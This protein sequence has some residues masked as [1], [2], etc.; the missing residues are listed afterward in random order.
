MCKA[1]DGYLV[2]TQNQHKTSALAMCVRCSIF[3][4]LIANL[5]KKIMQKANRKNERKTAKSNL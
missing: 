3:Q 2:R 4:V 1:F 5:I